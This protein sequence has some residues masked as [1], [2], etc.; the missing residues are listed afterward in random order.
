MSTQ[1]KSSVQQYGFVAYIIWYSIRMECFGSTSTTLIKCSQKTV[2]CLDFGHHCSYGRGHGGTNVI[3]ILFLLVDA[4]NCVL[5]FILCAR[6]KGQQFANPNDSINHINHAFVRLSY[7]PYV[8]L[9]HSYILTPISS[10]TLVVVSHRVDGD[11]KRTHTRTQP[12]V[13]WTLH[14]WCTNQTKCQ[15]TKQ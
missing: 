8:D 11:E 3:A 5:C 9:A 15:L 1:T 13:F 7:E 6:V 2:R 12:L 14:S 4:S 10:E